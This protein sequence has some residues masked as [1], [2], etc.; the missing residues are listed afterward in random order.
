M[1]SFQLVFTAITFFALLTGCSQRQAAEPA[2]ATASPAGSQ[3]LLT[4]EPQA[5]SEVIAAR[6]NAKDDEP[7]VVV[8]RIGGSQSPWVEGMAAFSIVDRSLK[9]CSDTEGDE[10]PTPWDYCCQTD[11]LPKATVLV[12][13][14]DDTGKVVDTDSQRLL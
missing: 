1:N 8:G 6:E 4:E 14:V 13:V 12:K 9:A 3:Y 5:A 10:C 11:L 7:V 2:P